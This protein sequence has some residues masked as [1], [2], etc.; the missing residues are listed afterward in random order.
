M[1]VIK[2]SIGQIVDTV[3]DFIKKY[4]E[5]D[6]FR[7][8]EAMDI[9]VSYQSMGTGEKCC[10]G[11]FIVYKRI[12]HITINCDLPRI[13]QRIVLA[14]EIGHAVLHAKSASRALAQFHDTALFDAGDSTE[15]EANL[16]ASELLLSDEAVMEALNDDL[17]FSQIA[18]ELYVPQEMLDFKFRVMKKKGFAVNPPLMAQSN[19]LKDFEKDIDRCPE[20]YCC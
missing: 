8:A 10:K 20:D 6:P 9:Q 19:F 14:H 7:L 1:S 18:S 17:Y 3:N 11:F 12:K 15:Y 16:F 13:M 4:D 5:T 2:Y